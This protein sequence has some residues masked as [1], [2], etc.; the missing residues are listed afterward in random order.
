MVGWF[1]ASVKGGSFQRADVDAGCRVAC[2]GGARSPQIGR[3]H[4]SGRHCG[5]GLH[6]RA[7]D[8]IDAVSIR[9]SSSGVEKVDL[10][11][12]GSKK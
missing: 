12:V 6:C 7:R 9:T 11:S 2:V 1:P 4:A 3:G 10:L 5:L 8:R